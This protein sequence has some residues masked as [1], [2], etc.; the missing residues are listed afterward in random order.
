MSVLG[1]RPVNG[2]RIFFGE[3]GVIVLGVLIALAI[4][5]IA[6]MVR[7]RIRA[8]EL[9]QSIIGEIAINAG[10]HEERALIQPCVARRLNEVERLLR[11]AR[12]TGY[13]PAV[14]EIGRPPIRPLSADS[15]DLASGSEALLYFDPGEVKR[16]SL[17]YGQIA[18]ISD[19]VLA[20]QEAW[21]TLRAIEQAPGPISQDLL[22]ELTLVASRLRFQSYL[23]G[24]NGKQGLDFATGFGVR[25][26]YFAL[27][28][29]DE[30][31]S[32]LIESLRDRPVCK[33]LLVDGRP[34]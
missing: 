34:T 31:R 29:K 13:L 15:W 28:E 14:G 3:V 26:R 30:P 20:E 7:W 4:G 32:T 33:P 24:L 23:N 2:W 21:A 5:V 19:R 12:R 22:T 10:V 8:A 11:T 1:F 16:L 18:R 9:R 25:P 27:F 17:H 6:D